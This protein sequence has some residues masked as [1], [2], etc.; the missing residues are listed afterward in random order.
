MD[1]GVHNFFAACRWH[2][3]ETPGTMSN[4]AK[5]PRR[6]AW[7]RWAPKI[8]CDI[9]ATVL[10][11]SAKH[12]N[13]LQG[14]QNLQRWHG[15]VAAGNCLQ[16]IATAQRHVSSVA[17]L[18]QAVE[19]SKEGRPTLKKYNAFLGVLCRRGRNGYF[20]GKQEWELLCNTCPLPMWYFLSSE[21]A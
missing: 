20:K 19:L 11:S 1:N 10:K 3:H 6:N 4:S 8:K 2:A 9:S 21:R 12:K 7:N 15:S 18:F 16:R 14:K 5:L 17:L 13:R